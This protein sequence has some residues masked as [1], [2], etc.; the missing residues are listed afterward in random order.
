MPVRY[1]FYKMPGLLNDGSLKDSPSRNLSL[2]RESSVCKQVDVSA[3]ERY[4]DYS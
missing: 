1:V 2:H 4:T 3:I